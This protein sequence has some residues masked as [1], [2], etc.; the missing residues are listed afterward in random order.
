MSPNRWVFDSA[1]SEE[2]TLDEKH[3][4]Y[5]ASS[6]PNVGMPSFSAAH[7]ATKRLALNMDLTSGSKA[8]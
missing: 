1:E 8:R 5:K 7:T 2:E 4:T 6:G 3:C